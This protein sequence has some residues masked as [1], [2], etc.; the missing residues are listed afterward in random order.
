MKLVKLL[1]STTI[2]IDAIETTITQ[3]NAVASGD[4]SKEIEL[5]SST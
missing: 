4:F 5:L 1:M 2:L 3:A